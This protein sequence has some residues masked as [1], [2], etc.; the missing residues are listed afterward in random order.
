MV[1]IL[2][3][4]ISLVDPSFVVVYMLCFLQIKIDYCILPNTLF[5]QENNTQAPVLLCHIAPPK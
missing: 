3:G 5:T 4:P 1:L 2:S